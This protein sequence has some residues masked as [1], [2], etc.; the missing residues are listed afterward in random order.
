MSLG[1][2]RLEGEKRPQFVFD[3]RPDQAVRLKRWFGQMNQ[4]R[5]GTLRLTATPQTAFDLHLLLRGYPL[6]M[7]DETRDVVR[8]LA[9][10]CQLRRERTASLRTSPVTLV[11]EL[12]EPAREYQL[13]AAAATQAS[14]CMLLADEMGLGKTISAIAFLAATPDA[15]PSVVVM[16]PHMLRQ[17]GRQL[18]RFAPKMTVHTVRSGAPYNVSPA[19]V[20]YAQQK[21][22][23]YDPHAVHPDVLLIS[24]SMLSKWAEVLAADP[25]GSLILDEAQ[26]L[27]RGT[28]TAKGSAASSI[29]RHVRYRL[30][31]SGTPV[32]NYGDEMFGVMDIIAPDHLGT[33][34]EFLR[35]WC[36]W[37]GRSYR[38]GFPDALGAK[39]RDDG[40]MLRRTRADVCRELPGLQKE[41]VD[42]PCDAKTLDAVKGQAG[43]LAR[44]LLA[45]TGVTNF[46]RLQASQEMIGV[47]R[48]ATG[49]GKAVAVADFVRKLI[50][51]GIRPVLYGWHRAVY[52]IWRAQLE[53]PAVVGELGLR[54]GFVTGEENGT[55]KDR[56]V[57][58]FIRAELDVLIVSLR[59]GAG[60]DG[61]QHATDTVVFGELDWSPK[62]HDQCTDRVNRDG[63]ARPVIAYYL[64]ADVGIDPIII[65]VC[66]A[67][68]SQSDP[69]LDGYTVVDGG[70]DDHAKR[71][72]EAVVSGKLWHT[73]E[74]DA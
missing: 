26:N 38:V 58:A 48:Q 9:R 40:V 73:T 10:E 6:D 53:A 71:V 7:D 4:A 35:E 39:L 36:H 74:G 33:R 44:T 50:A 19:D 12:A 60:I 43:E 41:I 69:I 23:P 30:G 47:L 16:E 2:L 65:D 55:A 22:T 15:R 20:P 8:Y 45:Q 52:D 14:R 28:D 32:Y 17:W 13:H 64:V 25:W 42:V 57:Q 29:A 66:G 54:V 37:T 1:T 46:A 67:K 51:D 31:L 59:S 27:R 49:I 21:R 61:L 24:Y 70:S 11:A 68:R 5:A 3:V 62:V 72:A 34:D 56:A 63:Q 18:H